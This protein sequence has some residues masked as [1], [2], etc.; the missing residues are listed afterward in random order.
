MRMRIRISVIGM[1][2][3]EAMKIKKLFP[4]LRKRRDGRDL[5]MESRELNVWSM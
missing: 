4:L 2:G 1:Q 5:M 3:T